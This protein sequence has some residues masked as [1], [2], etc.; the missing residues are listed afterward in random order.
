MNSN[1]FA[2]KFLLLF[3]LAGL[4]LALMVLAG[5]YAAAEQWGL[6]AVCVIVIGLD[7]VAGFAMMR[8][9]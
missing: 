8:A 9:K 6:V 5:K 2:G 4:M 3:I 1:S 7:A